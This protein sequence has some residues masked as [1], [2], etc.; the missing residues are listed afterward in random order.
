MMVIM[1][2]VLAQGA[3]GQL[4]RSPCLVEGMAEQ[5]VLRD[6]RFQLLKELSGIHSVLLIVPIMTQYYTGGLRS[7]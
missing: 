1:A 5:I 6:A 7:R 2:R 3:A 4:A